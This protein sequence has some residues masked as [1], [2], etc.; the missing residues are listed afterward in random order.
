MECFAHLKGIDHTLKCLHE[1]VQSRWIRVI[2]GIRH[3]SYVERLNVLGLYLIYGRL[4]R[5][6]VIKCVKN[7]S[8]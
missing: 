3:F 7:I 4:I 6:D 8:L 1:S 2:V 5:T